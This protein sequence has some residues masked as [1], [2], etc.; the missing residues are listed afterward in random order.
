MYEAIVVGAGPDAFQDRDGAAARAEL[1]G[2]ALLERGSAERPVPPGLRGMVVTAN[3]GLKRP[4]LH[5]LRGSVSDAELGAQRALV[6]PALE[7]P[8]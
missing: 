4:F 6:P 8:G 2:E 3:R 5:V 1:A 7:P